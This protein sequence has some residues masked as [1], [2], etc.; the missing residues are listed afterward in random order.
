MKG[1]RRIVPLPWLAFAALALA[2]P[3][4]PPEFTHRHA[5][6]WINSQ[7]LTLGALKGKVVLV[8]FWAFACD[9]CLNSRAWVESLERSKAPQGLVIVGVH[10]PEI[11]EERNP[12]AVRRA[13]ER[14]GIHYP[15]MIDGDSSY[16]HALHNQ[17]WP[18]FYLIGRDGR[19]YGSV[20]GE[21]HVG[22]ERA[23]KVE[24][25]IDQLLKAPAT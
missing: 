5:D 21:M 24:A 1:I 20:P 18:T 12:E 22:D 17:Y 7:P 11:A 16:W 13:V 15:V 8:E 4:V 23:Q 6:E 3:G 25:A 10:T 14:L 9:N 19:L 2:A